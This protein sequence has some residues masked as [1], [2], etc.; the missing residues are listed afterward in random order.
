MIHFLRNDKNETLLDL[1]VFTNDDGTPDLGVSID[2]ANYTDFLL[3]R[4]DDEQ[5]QKIKFVFDKLSE[6]RGW[7]WEVY[8]ETIN[9]NPTI[10][11]VNSVIG[12]MVQSAGNVIKLGYVT[13]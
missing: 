5:R 11:D 4:D 2:I 8:R 1:E 9:K 7:Y 12:L 10:K 3:S 6:S 13:D